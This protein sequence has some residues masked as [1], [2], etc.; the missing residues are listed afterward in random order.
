MIDLMPE[1]PSPSVVAILFGMIIGAYALGAA[2]TALVFRIVSD[3]DH[4]REDV[5]VAGICL[6]AA[7][8]VGP[9]SG[10]AWLGVRAADLLRHCHARNMP[11]ARPAR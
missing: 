8:L 6:L 11:P 10:V 7:A 3:E 2:M 1:D 9:I 4:D 5:A